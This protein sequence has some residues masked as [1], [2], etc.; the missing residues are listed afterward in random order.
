MLLLYRNWCERRGS[1]S[2]GLP[3]WHLKPARLPIPPLSQLALLIPGRLQQARIIQVIITACR[4]GAHL[5]FFTLQPRE[6]RRHGRRISSPRRRSRLPACRGTCTSLC[7]LPALRDDGAGRANDAEHRTCES[8]C[9]PTMYQDIRVPREEQDVRSGQMPCRPHRSRASL[10]SA[11]YLT[12]PCR[13]KNAPASHVHPDLV[14]RVGIEPTT[15][16]LRV[17]CSTN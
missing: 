5:D 11:M 16:G 14:G 15:N 12:S 8:D 7:I 1:N 6:N 3:H 2:N 13:Q 9:C 4:H 10:R 17:H